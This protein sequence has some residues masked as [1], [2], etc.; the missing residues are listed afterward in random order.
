MQS[1]GFIRKQVV[2]L[3]IREYTNLLLWGILIGFISAVVAVFPNFMTPGT[4]V[5]F[6]AV[7]LIV[8]AILAN[9]IIWIIAFSWLGLRKK[10]LI[11]NLAN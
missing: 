11:V 8:L 5:S 9:G 3:L 4:D 6:V 2:G 1:L 10:N 7:L